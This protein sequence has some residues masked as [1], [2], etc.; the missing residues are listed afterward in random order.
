MTNFYVR[1]NKLNLIPDSISGSPI[2]IPENSSFVVA[3]IASQ[4]AEDFLTMK[5][6][7]HLYVVVPGKKMTGFRLKDAAPVKKRIHDSSLVSDL[8]YNETLFRQFNIKFTQTAIGVTLRFDFDK[9]PDT[10]QAV[11]D[12]LMGSHDEVDL[13]VTKFLSVFELMSIHRLS[14]HELK[15]NK[16]VKIPNT[17]CAQRVSVWA[18]KNG[19]KNVRMG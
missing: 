13:Y 15:I 16:R 6:L 4:D 2:A 1:Y 5:K 12:S 9:L 14:L 11:Y 19:E 17:R 10:T 7:L 8:N 18:S 3:K